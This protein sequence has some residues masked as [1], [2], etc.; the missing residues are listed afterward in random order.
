MSESERR[1]RTGVVSL[2]MASF[3]TGLYY[4]CFKR[5]CPLSP[6]ELRLTTTPL[7]PGLVKIFAR[8]FTRITPSVVKVSVGPLEAQ[9]NKLTS[10]RLIHQVSDD[11]TDK[12]FS[13]QTAAYFKAKYSQGLTS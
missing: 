5:K 13:H 8:R 2:T 12:L 9:V 1:K 10:Q 3:I 11:S 7:I 4:A 6:P